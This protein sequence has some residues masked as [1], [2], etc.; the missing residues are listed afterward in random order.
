MANFFNRRANSYDEHM[1]RSVALFDKFYGNVA[2]PID[3]TKDPIAILDLGCGTGLELASI[4]DRAPN[5]QITAVDLSSEMLAKLSE[6]YHDKG[7][8]ITLVCVSFLEF[9]IGQERW[10]YIVSVMAMHHLTYEE[11]LRLYRSIYEGLKPGGLYI[12]GDD[13]VTGKE[14]EELLK[15]YD[16]LRRMYPE[17]ANGAYHI[18]IPFCPETQ[19]RL[20][21]NAGFMT[22]ETSWEGEQAAVFVA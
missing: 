10:D 16:R 12:E 11:K 20:L 3:R 17:V 5:C 8:Q 13:V 7:E 14:E 9:E 22:A 15:R 2:K 6:K 1:R 4:F 19:L 18:D 21:S